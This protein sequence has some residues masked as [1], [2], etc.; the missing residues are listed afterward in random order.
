M[1]R[2][3]LVVLSALI[4]PALAAQRPP[5]GSPGLT[6]PGKGVPVT[7]VDGMDLLPM[8]IGLDPSNHVTYT[9]VNAGRSAIPQPFVADIYLGGVR[10]DTYKHTPMAAQA[11]TQVVSQLARVDSCA[12]VEIKIVAD[13]QQVIA[14]ARETNNTQALSLTPK[15]PDLTVTAIKQDWQDLNVRYRIQITVQN[16]GNLATP[17]L[18]IA[19]AWGGPSGVLAGLDP[20]A[21][22][23][24]QDTQIDPL[25]PGGST[26]F[27]LSGVYLGTDKVLV[28]V[29][30][31]FFHQI[32]E[33]RTDNNL[34]T[35]QFG[36]G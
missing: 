14:E 2:P 17:H 8:G 7:P 30:L 27:H 3:I 28:K 33:K 23:I 9:M 22:P 25:A 1:R 11:Q 26:T 20:A 21:W 12:T 10:R 16:Q 18:V 6:L 19:R 5:V 36:P 34:G 13:A 31:D 4:A 32:V 15:C 29:Y 24:L 35:K